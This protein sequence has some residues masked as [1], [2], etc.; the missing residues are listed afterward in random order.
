MQ[1]FEFLLE[2]PAAAV[3]ALCDLLLPIATGGVA[4]EPAIVTVPG[5]ET[6]HLGVGLPTLVRAYLPVDGKLTSR[7]SALTQAMGAQPGIRL[8]SETLMAGEDWT[9]AWRRGLRVQRVGAIVVKPSFRRHRPRPHEIVIEIDPGLAFGTGDHATTRACLAAMQRVLRPGDLVLDLG[10][11]TGILAVAA[12][13]LGAGAVVAVDT[14]EFAVDA[15][16]TACAHNGVGAIVEQGSLDHPSVRL[17]A[18]FD[19]VLAN[20]TSHLHQSLAGA[21]LGVVRPGGH[22]VGSG[23]GVGALR[24]VTHA[25]RQAGAEAITTRRHGQWRSIVASKG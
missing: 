12:V 19:V 8:R 5:A 25:Y 22:V 15:A 24:P 1:W 14:D 20:L 10:T 2:V 21:I 4:C 17:L 11:G 9:T 18:P 13:R 23:I 3:D 16:R 7:R 6:Y